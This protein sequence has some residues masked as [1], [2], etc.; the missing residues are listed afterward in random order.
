MSEAEL[1][2]FVVRYETVRSCP[3]PN[4]QRL[5]TTGILARALSR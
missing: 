4:L 3:L 5:R 2:A 1:H